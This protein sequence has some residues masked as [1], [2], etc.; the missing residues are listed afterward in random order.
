MS[1]IFLYFLLI[2]V[3]A[4][5]LM[6]MDLDP[7][8]AFSGAATAI[9]NVGPGL[10]EVIGPDGNFSTLPDLAKWLMAFG[11]AHRT[12]W[13]SSPCWCSSCHASGSGRRF[14]RALERKTGSHFS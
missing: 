9:A 7:L 5:A 11:Y 13:S 4:V 6:A 14:R 2:G 3:L 8:T 10:G 12:A 1:F